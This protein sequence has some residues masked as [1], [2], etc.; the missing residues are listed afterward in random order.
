MYKVVFALL[1]KEGNLISFLHEEDLTTQYIK[2]N[3]F[4]T[5][6]TKN[7]ELGI[8]EQGEYT[9]VAYV[10]LA[11][12]GIRITKYQKVNAEIIECSRSEHG[13]KNTIQTNENKELIIISEIDYNLYYEFE[14]DLPY[15]KLVEFM[16]QAAYD[17]GMIDELIIEMFDGEN[18]IIVEAPKVEETNPEDE[19]IIPNEGDIYSEM[20]EEESSV[21]QEINEEQNPEENIQMLEKGQYRMKYIV[22]EEEQEAYVYV[23]IK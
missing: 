7:I 13:F 19:T 3:E 23:T 14:G 17:H 11:N 2:G 21:D 6:Q 22:A 20:Q 5:T 4:E 8:L 9:L 12:E 10:T 15:E 1:N 18:W 16:G